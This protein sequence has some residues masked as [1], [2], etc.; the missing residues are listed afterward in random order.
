MIFL[1]FLFSSFAF[2]ETYLVPCFDGSGACQ[3]QNA[4]KPVDALC[5]VQE[6]EF[7]AVVFDLEIVDQ[8]GNRRA[9]TPSEV[10]GSSEVIECSLNATEVQNQ[11]D[12]RDQKKSDEDKDKKDKSDSWIAACLAS[13]AGSVES[14]ICLE[15]GFPIE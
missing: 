9:W 1:I 7:G 4:D 5:E 15:R 3:V 13:K 8:D 10:V 6:S 14:L 12:L 11:I 2:S